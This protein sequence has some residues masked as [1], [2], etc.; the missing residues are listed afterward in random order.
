[1]NSRDGFRVTTY[2]VCSELFFALCVIDLNGGP[3]GDAVLAAW[4]PM[5]SNPSTGIQ[6]EHCHVVSGYVVAT[7]APPSGHRSRQGMEFSVLY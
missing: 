2:L 5:G 3:Q 7:H 4:A 6:F 1:M